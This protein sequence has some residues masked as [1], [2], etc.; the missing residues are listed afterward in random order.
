[1]PHLRWNIQLTFDNVLPTSTAYGLI[2]KLIFFTSSS[3]QPI[4]VKTLIMRESGHTLEKE[5]K[6]LLKSGH[7]SQSPNN[8]NNYLLQGRNKEFN[9]TRQSE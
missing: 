8:K 7:I 9:N 2:R 6:T 4:P 5:S 1:M 3:Q